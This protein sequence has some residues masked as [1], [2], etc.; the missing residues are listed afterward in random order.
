MEKTPSCKRFRLMADEY[1]EG[2]LTAAEMR[3]FEAHIA[4]CE[5]CHKEFEELRALKEA[6]RSAEEEMPEGLHSRIMA[7]IESEPK[8]KPRRKAAFFR[9]A[10]ISVACIMLCLSATLAITLIPMWR[11]GTGG[12][13]LPNDPQFSLE[14]TIVEECNKSDSALSQPTDENIEAEQTS[15]SAQDPA[16]EVAPS[17]TIPIPEN[18]FEESMSVAETAQPETMIPETMIPETMTPETEA[19]MLAPAEKVTESATKD[20]AETQI[21]YQ[22]AA[23]EASSVPGGEEITLALLIV[24]GLLAVAS[25]VAFLISLSSVRTSSAEKS[26]GDKE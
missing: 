22:D 14:D 9:G 18:T 8:K 1:I 13:G 7:S 5:E 21:T 6:I 20:G 11:S 10:A 25:F 19:D 16:P 4:E 24:S 2:E 26:N 23:P 12:E 15:A 3:E 17:D